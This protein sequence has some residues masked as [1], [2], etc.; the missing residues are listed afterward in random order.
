MP[1]RL[2]HLDAASSVDLVVSDLS[3]VVEFVMD[4]TPLNDTEEGMMVP[5]AGVMHA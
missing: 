2:K 4:I 3:S 5:C 1:R